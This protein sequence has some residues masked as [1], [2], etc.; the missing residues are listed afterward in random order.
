M[1]VSGALELEPHREA[2]DKATRSVC[3]IE[4]PQAYCKSWRVVVEA[5]LGSRGPDDQ[6]AVTMPGLDG[7]SLEK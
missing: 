3:S 2:E 4:Q 5:T 7:W 6:K 1:V